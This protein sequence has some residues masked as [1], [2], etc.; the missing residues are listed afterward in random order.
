MIKK[1]ITLFLVLLSMQLTAAEKTHFVIAVDPEYIPFTQKDIEGSPTGLLVDLWNH[2]A[3]KNSYT[4][5]YKFYPWEETLNATKEGK[6]DFHSGTTQDRDWM[7][8]SDEIYELHTTLF[9]LRNSN[10]AT[11]K[12][13]ENKR[14][15]TIDAYYGELVNKVTENR[16][17]V[18]LYDDYLPMVEALKRGEID[19]L[20][21]DVEAVVY[22]FI[23]TGQM[24]KF[25]QVHDEKLHFYNKIFAITNIENKSLLK[26]INRGLNR[27]SLEKLSNIEKTWLPSVENAFYNKKLKAHSR[28]TSKEEKWL[29]ENKNISLIGDPLWTPTYVN[30]GKNHYAGIV[31]DY[32]CVISNSIGNEFIINS[33]NSWEEVLNLEEGIKSDIIFGSMNKETKENLSQRYDFLESYDFGSM[34]IVMNKSVRFVTSLYDIQTKKIGILSSQE[35]TKRI[36][37]K[38]ID[39][40]LEKIKTVPLLLD[41]IKKGEIDAGLLS[42]SKAIN[43]LVDDRYHDLD[44][45]GEIDENIYV[46]IG[47][48]KEKPILKSILEK[49]LLSLDPD[50]K[51][52]ILSKWTRRLNYIE[53]IDYKLTYSVASL[54]GLLLLTT[55]YYA[56]SIRRKHKA[57]QHMNTKIEYLA[58]V[59]DLTGLYNKRA[60]NQAFE[61]N[62]NEKEISGLLFVDVDYFKKYNDFYGHLQGDD[63]LEK[64][65]EQLNHYNSHHCGAYRIGGEEFGV[66]IYG[67]S[68]EN[69]FELAEKLRLNIEALK[70]DHPE[71]PFGYITVSIGVAIA[72]KGWD[73][74][75]LYQNADKALYKAKVL[76]RNSIFLYADEESIT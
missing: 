76:G 72:K 42:L 17:S 12:D 71:S 38:Y 3:E 25:K 60:F 65:G 31:G 15:G 4:V 34:V 22:Y 49:S 14:I 51:V 21:D 70:I 54:L 37:S 29:A 46:D 11:I 74:R 35:Y 30:D 28:Y 9:T 27:L 61:E 48:L 6:V 44:I 5:E 32:I 19:A 45:V 53:K 63:T 18:K 36:T 75:S 41:A 20:V 64:I 56:Y 39:Y 59:D 8:A 2:W 16:V 50:Y 69:I 55:G 23:K 73:I 43:F 58:S 40:D 1:Y 26:Q 66:I 13:I 67:H 7:Q 24:H 10:I 52:K 57:V 62:D 47:V 33:V 68:E